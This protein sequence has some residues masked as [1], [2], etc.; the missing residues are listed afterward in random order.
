MTQKNM[1]AVDRLWE[2]IARR[3]PTLTPEEQRAGIVLLREL[4]KGEPVTA[5]Q[6]AR[7]IGATTADAKTVLERPGLKPFVYR[8]E[9][10]RVVG[11]L[12]L[13]ARP[14]HHQF[15][16]NGRTLW[17]WCAG[18]SLFLP[19][20]LDETAEVESRDPEGGELIRLTISPTRIEA[21]EPEGVVV[22]MVK[23]DAPDFGSAAL[24]MATACHFI[25][26][27]ASRATGE[28]W[29]AKH[30]RTWLLSLNEAFEFGKRFNASLFATEL[31][32][33]AAGAA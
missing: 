3:L 16:L 1:L 26:F 22:C 32:R 20:L 12:G 29:V 7:A 23:P 11:Y 27:F 17:T 18:D 13:A 5:A 21:V 24:I 19:G 30:P 31:G 9:E 4:A 28:R 14:M 8:D 33:Q 25:F 15:A 10:G 2:A 6:L